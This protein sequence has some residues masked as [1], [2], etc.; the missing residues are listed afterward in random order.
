MT[1]PSVVWVVRLRLLADGDAVEHHRQVLAGD[2]LGAVQ[3]A[4]PVPGGGDPDG[5]ADEAVG[6]A[7]VEVGPED[8]GVDAAF[9]G[10]EP[11]L[12]EVALGFGEEGEAL[13]G[14]E[15]PGFLL[16]DRD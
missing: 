11:G 5:V 8:L 15:V 12:L 7:D 3:T 9:Q 14:D 4:G 16:V 1:A 10:A 2:L 6:E 13:L